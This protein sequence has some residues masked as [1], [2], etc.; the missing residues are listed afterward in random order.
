MQP[1]P[2]PADYEIAYRTLEFARDLTPDD[3]EL[4]RKLVAAAWS[5]GD[6]QRLNEASR[7]LVRL[8]PT[9]SV[10]QLRL[11]SSTIARQQTAEARL[12]LYE[13][14]LGEAGAKLDPAIRSRLAL[15]AALLLREQGDDAGFASM[16]N[17][18]M[19]LDGSNKAA[20]QLAATFYGSRVSDPVGR[21]EMLLNLLYADPVDPNIYQS[22]AQQLANHG[23]L[24]QAER[25]FM[26]ASTLYEKSG[27]IPPQLQQHALSLRWQLYGPQQTLDT[28]THALLVMREEKQRANDA[29]LAQGAHP[30]DLVPPS[31]VRLDADKDQIRLMAAM[32]VGDREGALKIVED[33]EASVLYAAA[34]LFD[35]ARR[36]SSYTE[37]AANEQGV[38]LLAGLQVFRLWSGVH[39]EEVLVDQEALA[40]QAAAF[41][42]ILDT[43]DPWLLLRDEKPLEALARVAELGPRSGPLGQIALAVALERLGRKDEAIE[44]L[45]AFSDANALD[46]VAAW[47]RTHAARLLG[48]PIPVDPN[49]AALRAMAA[50]VPRF[51]DDMIQDTSTFM[52]LQI[53]G[54]QN[55]TRVND[56]W[57]VRVRL[58]NLAPIPLAVGS[59]R[60]IN[61]R[62]MLQPM[63]DNNFAVFHGELYPEVIELN[64]RL[65]LMPRETI[66][67]DI[68]VDLGATGMILALN[69]LKN[70]RLKWRAIQGFVIGHL[71]T[72]RPGPMCLTAESEAAELR[73]NPASLLS[74][75]EVG[76]L[77]RT[78]T[79]AQLPDVTQ[80]ARSL[81]M[82]WPIRAERPPQAVAT[83]ESAIPARFQNADPLA[84]AYMLATLPAFRM[85]P[86][87]AT[88]DASALALPTDPDFR[89]SPHAELLESLILLTRVA[90]PDSQR[91]ADAETSGSPRVAAIARLVRERLADGRPCFATALRFEDWFPPTRAEK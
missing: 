64:R 5:S 17:R 19:A 89:A 13:R 39:L 87:M 20:A 79:N 82:A 29:L 40:T 34:Q 74:T 44:V 56:P 26:H 91:L 12:T 43:I 66:E 72:F 61:S 69:S 14:F 46:P 33:L 67:A 10:A 22:I 7:N 23:V 35:P 45:L 65:R 78:C 42:H 21:F 83:I 68:S 50:G 28:M 18:A 16:L 37:A 75:Q 53:K 8:D 4:A 73:I 55:P 25:F 76:V 6:P 54:I 71:E 24:D 9:D 59:D 49:A 90:D 2:S 51:I 30:E 32:T 36:P 38:A 81:L 31:E 84:R 85:Q 57:T 77:M 3:V 47:A 41:P 70:H 60:P 80:L 1:S 48:G 58:R 63:R 62:I 86:A 11:I 15:D 88:L 52:S 27:R